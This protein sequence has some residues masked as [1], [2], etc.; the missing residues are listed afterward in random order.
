[1]LHLEALCYES[2]Q[3]IREGYSKDTAGEFS[4][5]IKI[6]R[7]SLDELEGD[8]DDCFEDKLISKEKYLLN[9]ENPRS[10]QISNGSLFRC[11]A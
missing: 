2:K 7:G 6:S 4:H 3:N 1:M 8:F 9:K 11:S 5:S 10:N